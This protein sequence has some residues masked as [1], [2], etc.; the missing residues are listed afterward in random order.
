MTFAKYPP[1]NISE[2]ITVFKQDVEITHEIVHGDEN[3][4]V[5]TENG[6]VPSFKNVIEFLK[7]EVASATG[8]DV[9]LRSDLANGSADVGGLTAAQITES[10][11]R[12]FGTAA[13]N[14]VDLINAAITAT[15][16]AYVPHATWYH[17][18]GTV[19]LDN[20]ESIY[21]ENTVI[22]SLLDG[23]GTYAPFI[24]ANEKFGWSVRGRCYYKGSLVTG[25]DVGNE[26]ALKIIGGDRYAV[27]NF[28]AVTCRSHGFLIAA[29][30][31]A[32]A[33]RGDQGQIIGCSAH[34]SRVGF[35][36]EV[37]ASTEFCVVTNFTAAGNLDGI[38]APAGNTIFVGGNCVDNTRGYTLLGGPNHAHGI[39]STMNIDH[40]SEYDIKCVGVVNGHTFNGIHAY[41]N[42]GTTG[43]IIFENS[44]GVVVQNGKIDGPI[45][46]NGTSG[47]N[48][49]LNNHMPGSNAQILGTNPEYLRV[50]GNWTDNGSWIANDP[51]AEFV[52][53]SRGGTAQALGA[54]T[55]LIFNS[56][57]K[58]KRGLLDA[59]TGVTDIPIA[60]VAN[61]K[62]SLIMTATGMTAGQSI[63]FVTLLR[64]SD[65]VAFAPVTAISS[66]VAI[67]NF[68][69]SVLYGAAG[70]LSVTN[71]AVAT[72]LALAVDQSRITVSMS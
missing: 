44:K 59:D 57:I 40:N 62:C 72:D 46:N 36:A 13:D 31:L 47:Q 65:T 68:S 45:Y 11:I 26:I 41:N 12:K 48:A 23:G 25:D 63:G 34:Q 15:G 28:T 70:T 69:E 16:F 56:P 8:V 14:V 71:S 33:P 51:A 7:D 29:G 58:D 4:E 1:E 9:S 27:E 42:G 53:A 5:L 64:N 66:T 18:G 50:L 10:D 24:V 30:I 35:E 32:P 20:G 21:F 19:D 6:L 55:V 61:V 17:R 60:G 49:I 37:H 54:N 2:A 39:T 38:I 67:C 52:Q 43:G 3:T 22:E